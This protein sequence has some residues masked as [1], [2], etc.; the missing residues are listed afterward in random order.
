[1][2]KSPWEKVLTLEENGIVVEVS[3]ATFGKGPARYSIFVGQREKD[4]KIYPDIDL[5][6]REQKGLGKPELDLNYA[7]L[8]GQML[9]KAQ[10]HVQVAMESSWSLWLE[11]RQEREQER[12]QTGSKPFVR[13]PGKTARDKAKKVHHKE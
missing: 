11:R 7:V 13:A 4:G 3:R 10:E 12:G 6:T 5:L 2:N 1:M 9:V 8:L